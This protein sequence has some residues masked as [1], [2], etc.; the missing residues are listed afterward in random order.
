MEL[1]VDL[2]TAEEKMSE[3]E[4]EN[5]NSPKLSTERKQADKI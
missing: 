4:N 5:R 3:F 1:T 2:D